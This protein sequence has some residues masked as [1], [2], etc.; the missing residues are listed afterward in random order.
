MY[1]NEDIVFLL[2][3]DDM[4]NEQSEVY[5]DAVA[6]Q[7]PTKIP[8]GL[9]KP[10][11]AM[12]ESGNSVVLWHW[13]AYEESLHAAKEEA[14]ED[15]ETATDGGSVVAEEQEETGHA[16]AEEVEE[17]EEVVET[18]EESTEEKTIEAPKEKFKGFMTIRELNAKGFRNLADQPSNSQNSKGKGYWENGKWKVMITRPLITGDKKIDIQFE[19][20]KLIPYALAVWD[21]S[22]KEIGGQKSITSWYYLTLEMPTPKSVY[23]YVIIAVIMAV[24]IQFWVIGKIRR[25]PTEIPVE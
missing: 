4:T 17:A 15:S 20:G 3:W 25:F 10:Y 7:F 5:S 12:G 9:K 6:L 23:F 13:R 11:F 24:S 2:E 1:N 14:D 19:T 18:Q 16:E 21:G 8:E 22:N